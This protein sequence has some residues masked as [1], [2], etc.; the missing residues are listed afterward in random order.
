[1]DAA[2]LAQLGISGPVQAFDGQFGLFAL[3]DAGD[4]SQAFDDLGTRFLTPLTTFKKFPSCGCSHAAIEAALQLVRQHGLAAGDIEHAEVLITPYMNR[5]VGAPFSTDGDAEV[6]G[7]FCAQY[8]VAAVLARGRFTLADIE[9][10]AVLDEALRPRLARV[11][12]KVD[13][14]A[15]GT[16]APATVSVVL[17]DGRRLSHTVDT[18]P[19]GAEQPLTRDDLRAKAHGALR[20]GPGGLSEAGALALIERIEHLEQLDDVARLFD[21][22]A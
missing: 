1:V 15:T 13:P 19:G 5:L 8:A 3:Y 12:V 6:T 2:Q 20:Q 11:Q 16:M 18:L 10:A 17:R 9:P 4:P 7:Q 21:G 22:I 14:Q